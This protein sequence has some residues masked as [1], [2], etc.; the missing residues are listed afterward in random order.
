ML[1]VTRRVEQGVARCTAQPLH[2]GGAGSGDGAVRPTDPAKGLAIPPAIDLKPNRQFHPN[3]PA[4]RY[5][6]RCTHPVRHGIWPGW[7]LSS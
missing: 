7:S 6:G 5:L 2:Y 3:L 4:A 1:G